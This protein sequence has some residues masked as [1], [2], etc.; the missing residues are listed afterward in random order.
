MKTFTQFGMMGMVSLIP[1]FH[2]LTSIK[3]K[4]NTLRPRRGPLG[5]ERGYP[6]PQKRERVFEAL[7]AIRARSDDRRKLPFAFI[8][9]IQLGLNEQMDWLSSLSHFYLSSL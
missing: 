9:P 5:V 7:E 4:K 8:S 6:A 3:D 2:R 1:T